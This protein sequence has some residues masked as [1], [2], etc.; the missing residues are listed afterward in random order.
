MAAH[1]EKPVLYYALGAYYA[2]VRGRYGDQWLIS[3]E[4]LYE[5]EAE[6]FRKAYD[7]GVYDAFSLSELATSY[8]YLYVD[9]SLDEDSLP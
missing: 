3:V 4:E 7:G 2:D 8:F 1:G 6:N 9:P 5:K